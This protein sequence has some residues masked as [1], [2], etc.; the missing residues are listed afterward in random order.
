MRHVRAVYV[1]YLVFVLLGVAYCTVLGLV[2]R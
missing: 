2:G 1:A